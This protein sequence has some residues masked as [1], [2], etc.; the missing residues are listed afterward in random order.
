M[1]A[2]LTIAAAMLLPL[3]AAAFAAVRFVPSDISAPRSD[4]G[5]SPAR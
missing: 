5:A 2:K 3:G 1:I 4:L